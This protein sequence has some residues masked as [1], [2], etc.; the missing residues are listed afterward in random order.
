[1]TGRL[2]SLGALALLLALPIALPFA[3]SPPAGRAEA[4]AGAAG[5]ALAAGPLP[6]PPRSGGPSLADL[7][8]SRRSTRAFSKEPLKRDELAYLLW[9][10]GGLNRPE[11]KKR[12]SPSAYEAYAVSIY[13]TSADGTSIYDPPS[14]SLRPAGAAGGKD[15]RREI[16]RAA[17]SQEAP[18]LLVLVADF[19]RYPE[20]V[21]PESRRYYAHADCGVIA[22][23]IYLAAGALG[24]GTVMAAD[25]R[26]ESA[27]LL[28]LGTDQMA[29][30]VLP[31]G[32]AEPDSRKEKKS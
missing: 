11:E 23:N 21:K 18:A 5:S 7:L 3:A 16:P 12:T 26:P 19:S 22:E 17:S 30:Y 31:V 14:H 6:A 4:Q 1:M 24:L 13:V 2:M 25:A 9:A 8:W 29:L 20:R 15:L 32:H 27:Q 28:G 10:G